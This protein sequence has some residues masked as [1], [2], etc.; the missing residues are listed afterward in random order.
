MIFWSQNWNKIIP[1]VV[2][3]FFWILENMFTV[4]SSLFHMPINRSRNHLPVFTF[5]KGKC[6]KKNLQVEWHALFYQNWS[7]L[8]MILMMMLGAGVVVVTCVNSNELFQQKYRKIN[9]SSGCRSNRNRFLHF[10]YSSFHRLFGDVKP[11]SIHFSSISSMNTH[12]NWQQAKTHT[13]LKWKEKLYK[14][15]SLKYSNTWNTF[16]LGLAWADFFL[17]ST[18]IR[19]RQNE[20][21][22][23]LDNECDERRQKSERKD[24]ILFS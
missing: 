18:Q 19:R 10:I 24:F 23:K 5:R 20:W 1:F 4:I 16:A 3:L 14:I 9:A 12:W 22:A 15:P 21:H 8:F 11:K 7:F 2:V 13:Q 6:P 17:H